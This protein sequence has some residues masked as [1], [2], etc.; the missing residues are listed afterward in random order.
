MAGKG[1]TKRNI[2][3]PDELWHAALDGAEEEGTNVSA[4]VNEFLREKYLPEQKA[5]S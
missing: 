5:A 2:R 3:I 1:T 4:V